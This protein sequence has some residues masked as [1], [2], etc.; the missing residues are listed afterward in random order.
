[1]QD[2]ESDSPRQLLKDLYVA[3]RV[4]S[5]PKEPLCDRGNCPVDDRG[6]G[7]DPEGRREL[8]GVVSAG[9]AGPNCP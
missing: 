2:I 8:A 7:L 6:W 1:M 9:V 4:T 5:S 3:L